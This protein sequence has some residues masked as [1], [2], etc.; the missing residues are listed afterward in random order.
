MVISDNELCNKEP[1]MKVFTKP[2]KYHDEY[3]KEKKVLSRLSGKGFVPKLISYQEMQITMEQIEAPSLMEY[4]FE[5]GHIPYNLAKALY[6]IEEQLI[7]I[8]D[9]HHADFYKFAEHIFVDEESKSPE[10][11]GIRVIDFAEDG[12]LEMEDKGEKEKER[13][14]RLKALERRYLFLKQKDN[15]SQNEFCDLLKAA[16]CNN[17]EIDDFLKKMER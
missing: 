17:S 1:T 7:R 9:I 14:K 13:E 3:E 4:A 11:K 15:K 5:N 10:T 6:Y 12:F 8:D 2:Y 16:G